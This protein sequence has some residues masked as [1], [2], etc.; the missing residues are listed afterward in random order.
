[1]TIVIYYD[2]L[3]AISDAVSSSVYIIYITNKI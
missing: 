3:Y 1:M 2:S